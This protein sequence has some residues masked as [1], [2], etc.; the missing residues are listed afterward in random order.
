MGLVIEMRDKSDYVCRL[1]DTKNNSF[2][3]PEM[4]MVRVTLEFFQTNHDLGTFRNEIAVNRYHRTGE[5]DQTPAK[6]QPRIS[7]ASLIFQVE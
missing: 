4:W 6:F 7:A 2:D 5:V 1:S 3:L